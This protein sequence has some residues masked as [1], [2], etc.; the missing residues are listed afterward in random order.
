MSSENRNRSCRHFDLLERQLIE[1]FK[2]HEL[3]QRAPE[4]NE[5]V[6][7]VTNLPSRAGLAEKCMNFLYTFPPVNAFELASFLNLHN[8]LFLPDIP[9]D[10][11]ENISINAADFSEEILRMKI[12]AAHKSDIKILIACAPKSASTFLWQVL[13]NGLNLPA[14]YLTVP[15]NAPHFLGSNLREEVFDELAILRAIICQNG[16]VCHHHMQMN[17][18]GAE[19]IQNYDIKPIV[20]YRNIFDS[21]ISMDDM[22]I[23]ERPLGAKAAYYF[24][25]RLPSNYNDLDKDDRLMLIAQTTGAWL[26]QFYLSW[27]MCERVGYVKPLWI[28][29]DNDILGDKQQLAIRIASF[30]GNDQIDLDKLFAAFSHDPKKVARFNKGV[31]GRGKD[32]PDKVREFLWSLASPYEND[33]DLSELMGE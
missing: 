27:K 19:L 1:M 11:V 15:H 33:V 22:R 10:F 32:V 6:R 24:D 9:D 3:N 16:F 2:S 18:Y 4:I 8:P 23:K 30:L 29:Y 25:D 5:F 26:I 17:L 28:S 13:L 20:T 7:Q 31:A 12:T 14:G 21:I